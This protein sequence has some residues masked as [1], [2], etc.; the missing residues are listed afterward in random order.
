VLRVTLDFAGLSDRFGAGSAVQTAD[1]GSFDVT[2]TQ[3]RS[4]EGF[5]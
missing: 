1:L 2:L 5:E 3:I 4:G